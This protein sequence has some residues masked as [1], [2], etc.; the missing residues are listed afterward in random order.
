MQ[1]AQLPTCIAHTVYLTSLQGLSAL[2]Y[3]RYQSRISISVCK[4]RVYHLFG[5][6]VTSLHG[7]RWIGYHFGKMTMHV[8]LWS[9]LYTDKSSSIIIRYNTS[10]LHTIYFL[11]VYIT[12]NKALVCSQVTDGLWRNVTL[13]A[14]AAW[15]GWTTVCLELKQTSPRPCLK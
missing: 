13:K 1:W 14:N 15:D 12:L 11:P 3:L 2:A 9:V 8:L 6:A 4:H 5:N 10:T 7:D